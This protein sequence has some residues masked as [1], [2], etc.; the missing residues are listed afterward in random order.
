M[1]KRI[2]VTADTHFGHS[3]AIGLFARPVADGDVHSMDELLLDRINTRVQREDFLLHLGDFTGPRR[4]KGEE[5]ALSMQ[6]ALD[7]RR[8]IYCK[9]IEILRGNHDPSCKRLRDIFDDAHD[10]HSFRGW[11][12]GDERV[13]CCHYPLRTWQGI[14]DGAVHLYGHTHGTFEA[15][16]RS[17]DVGVDCFDYGP[18]L[19]D[20]VMARIVQ[21][22][23]PAR[24]ES[25]PR[26]QAMRHPEM[27]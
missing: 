24:E 21:Q 13:V 2:W 25:L 19:L 10:L 23:S 15:L 12:G 11:T 17:C 18:V 6:F 4:W 8:R 20:E 3:E 9:K 22:S 7:L 26:R 14:F 16:G 1:A 5:G 27:Q